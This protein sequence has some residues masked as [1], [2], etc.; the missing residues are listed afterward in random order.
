MEDKDTHLDLWLNKTH[1]LN[2]KLDDL[3]TYIAHTSTCSP[4]IWE[5]LDGGLSFDKA[6]NLFNSWKTKK[7][8][9]LSYLIPFLKENN[10]V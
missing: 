10:I 5:K 3:V 6:E 8:D 9:D 7:F 4:Y 2:L 1:S